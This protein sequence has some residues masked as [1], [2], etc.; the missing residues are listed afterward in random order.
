MSTEDVVA[1]VDLGKTRCRIVVSGPSGEIAAA[2]REGLPGLAVSGAPART[3]EV[4][5]TLLDDVA[6]HLGPTSFGIGAAGALTSPA[7]AEEL[8]RLLAATYAVPVAVASDIVTAHAGAFDGTPG[9]CLV[10]GTGA[11]SLG[12]AADGRHARH[13]GLGLLAG[14]VGSGAWIGRAGI[15]AAAM[16]VAGAAAPTRL[17]DLIAVSGVGAA[18]TGGEDAARLAR[19]APA[20]LAAAADGDAAALAIVDAATTELAATAQAAA[21]ATGQRIVGV[22]GGLTGSDWFMAKLT[23]ALS[24]RDLITRA[25]A[26]TALDG[27]RI[28]ATRDDLPLK[29]LIHRA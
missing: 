7:G 2:T 13:D 26:G 14:D 20:V 28:I 1:C 18:P 27:A 19:Y 10:V 9:V 22:L 4:L 8:A 24:A 5:R 11:V 6:P 23:T 17:V 16:A 3:A 21:L 12:V 15:R 29:G 25:P